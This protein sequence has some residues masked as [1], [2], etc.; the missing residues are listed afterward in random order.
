MPGWSMAW[1]ARE[2]ETAE[3]SNELE[4]GG[5]DRDSNFT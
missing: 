5:Q 1:V 2:L 3:L 4:E